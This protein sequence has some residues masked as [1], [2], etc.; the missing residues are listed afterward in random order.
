MSREEVVRIAREC[1]W[2]KLGRGLEYPVLIEMLERFHSIATAAER[3][4]CAKACEARQIIAPF[5]DCE[6]HYNQAAEHCA[7]AIRA[8]GQEQPR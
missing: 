8:R 7:F 3:E 1:G 2:K 6:H 5:Y 4:A